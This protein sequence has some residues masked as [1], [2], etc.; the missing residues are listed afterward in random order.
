MTVDAHPHGPDELC[1][2]GS[3]LY[4]RALRE[5]HVASEDAD[6]APCLVDLGLL[7][8]ASQG[9]EQLRPVPPSVAL[10][11]LL[12]GIEDRIAHHRRQ[13]SLLAAAFEPLM[14]VAAQQPVSQQ[15]DV[16]PSAITV[17]NGLPRIQEAVRKAISDSSREMLVI[18]PGGFRTP[19]EL[20][21]SLDDARVALA[22]GVRL[23]TLYQHTTRHSLP[24]LAY[25][26]LLDGDAEVRTLDE[27]TE[28][29]F[30]FDR[31]VAFIPAN[32]ERDVALEIQ[33]PAL[34]DYLGTTFERFWRLATPMYPTQVPI[35]SDNGFSP[36]QRAAAVLLTEGLTD[37]EI[38]ARLGM[39]IRTAR[40]HIAKLSE[41]LGSHSRAQLGFL[42]GQSGIL[43]HG[44]QSV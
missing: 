31:T 23:R 18:Q 10:P 29:L 12:E 34:V 17:L 3:E 38:A 14:A 36:R 41:R 7:R 5:G 6:Q 15:A 39:N 42:I 22:R 25:Y 11:R 44:E 24:V 2:A 8:P 4:A 27:V 37:G 40:V 32:K 13:E 43:D 1:A 21:L 28:R 30:V 26:E 9:N 16:T 19:E 35:A 20:A 33:H